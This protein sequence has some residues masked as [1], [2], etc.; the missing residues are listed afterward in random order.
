DYWGQGLATEAVKNI[1]WLGLHQMGLSRISII[2]HLE[3]KASQR[4]AEKSDYV[5]LKQ[6]KG[7]DRYSH[8]MRQYRHYYV[9]KQM[10]K[11]AEREKRKNDY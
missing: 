8:Q 11:E 1:T 3:N 10:L 6:Y 9:T 2:A 7:S 5:L 4:V